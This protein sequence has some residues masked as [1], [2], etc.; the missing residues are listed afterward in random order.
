VPTCACWFDFPNADTPSPRPEQAA[1]QIPA[2]RWQ[3][4]SLD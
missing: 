1:T 3:K 4:L 2:Q